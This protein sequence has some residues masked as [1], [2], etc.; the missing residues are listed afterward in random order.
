MR[1]QL[2]ETLEPMLALLTPRLPDDQEQWGFEFKWDGER[3]LAF[4]DGRALRL[5]S[6]NRLEVTAQYPEVAGLAAA[7]GPEPLLLDGEIVARDERGEISFQRLARRMHRRVGVQAAA[8]EA[9]VV[10]LIFDLLH[11]DGASLLAA[12]YR[13]RRARLEAL[14]LTGPAWRTPA[15]Y[16]GAGEAVLAAAREH[17]L[18]G[19][20]AKRLDSRYEP[21]RR[22]GAWRKL[23]LIRRQEFVI[24]GWTDFRQSDPGRIGALLVGYWDGPGGKQDPPPPAGA[25]RLYYAGG[26]GTGFTEAER[27]ALAVRLAELQRETA[28]FT[29]PPP[30]PAHWAEP[31]LVAE[32]EYRGWTRDSLLRQAAFKGLR[33]DKPAEAVVRE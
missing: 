2:P 19:V 16:P 18:E 27:E 17:H 21:G 3:I 4:W 28:P 13:E 33:E 12:P 8:R 1:V 15:F 11:Q 23:K 30:R 26:V 32:I 29:A 9:P 6:R 24:G 31:V 14:G 5:Q 20:V 22:S 25:R 7:L 10:Y